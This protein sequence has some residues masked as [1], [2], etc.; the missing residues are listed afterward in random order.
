MAWKNINKAYPEK[1]RIVNCS[2]IIPIF[3]SLF[4][5]SG[6][7]E[8]VGHVYL[9]KNAARPANPYRI[10]YDARSYPNSLEVF[11]GEKKICIMPSKGDLIERW[12]FIGGGDY[13]AIRSRGRDKQIVLELFKT[14][15]CKCVDEIELPALGNKNALPLW[16]NSLFE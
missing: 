8:R 13:M 3:C 1:H 2:I 7:K 15:S 6:C 5:V 14:E 16:A 9:S 10:P 11:K 12:G 4:I